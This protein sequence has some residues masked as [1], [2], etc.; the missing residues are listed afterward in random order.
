MCQLLL[1]NNYVFTFFSFKI[2]ICLLKF[3]FRFY[4]SI[5]FNR[6]ELLNVLVIFLTDNQVLEILKLHFKQMLILLIFR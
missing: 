5:L 2:Y 4:I 1:I 3:F 6:N